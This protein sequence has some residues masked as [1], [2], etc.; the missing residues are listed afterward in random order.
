MEEMGEDEVFA[1]LG[2]LVIGVIAAGIW[3]ARGLGI[4]RLGAPPGSRTLLLL[5]PPIALLGLQRVLTAF[6][7]VDVR[8]DGRYQFLFVAMGSIWVFVLPRALAIIGVSYRDD[9]LERRNVAASTAIAGTV[10]G[11][12]ILFAGS[13]MG[14]GPSIWNT[15]ETAIAATAMLFAAVLILAL[16]TSIGDTIAVERDLSSGVRFAGWI[17]ASGVVLGRASA[18][19]WMGEDAMIAD[20]VSVGWPVAV[21][22]A[23]AVAVELT[24]RPKVSAPQPNVVTAGVVPAAVYLAVSLAYVASLPS[25]SS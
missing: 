9:A 19:D 15:V 1:M 5:L 20:L 16:A 14:E 22:L 21:F 4:T 25:W 23:V 13:N 12:T 18:G 24:L 10:L 11:L 17:A 3:Y 7:A 2:S 8:E 6:A